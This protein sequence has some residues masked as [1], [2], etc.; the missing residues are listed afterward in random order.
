MAKI[1]IPMNYYSNANL[2]L[3]QTGEI[4]G[5]EI[6][7]SASSDNSEYA[8]ISPGSL[9]YYS[10]QSVNMLEE[11]G[12]M[13]KSDTLLADI[14][15]ESSGDAIAYNHVLNLATYGSQ[16]LSLYRY[17]QNTGERFYRIS[18]NS[19]GTENF[20]NITL[21]TLIDMP[22]GFL[23]QDKQYDYNYNGSSVSSNLTGKIRYDGWENGGTRRNT[24]IVYEYLSPEEKDKLIE[25]FK[26]GKG[27]MPVWFIEDETDSNTWMMISMTSMFIAEPSADYFNV[28]IN[29]E[30]F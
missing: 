19:E 6:R 28:S 18:H 20:Q 16:G 13:V 10:Y 11:M 15:L 26:L 22:D 4:A 24:Q 3:S 30:E 1:L 29:V 7:K 9:A 12:V 21:G 27:V 5:Y 17:V 2:T 23:K 25:V 14:E 8:K